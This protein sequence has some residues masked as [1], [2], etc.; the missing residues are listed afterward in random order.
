[1][2]VALRVNKLAD[3]RHDEGRQGPRRC[4]S[5]LDRGLEREAVHHGGEHAHGIAGRTRYAARGDF[6]AAD[7]VSAA[8]DHRDLGAELAGGDQFAGDPVDGRLIDAEGLRAGEVF[9]GEL[10]HHTT[11]DR[12]SHCETLSFPRGSLPAQTGRKDCS[13]GY[14]L[15]LA[16]A[17]SAAKSDS[18]F[19]IPSPR[20]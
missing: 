7:D 19:S 8:D 17:T 16:A 4:P 1:M 15:P 13:G 10:D 9:A 20:A 3:L 12:L 6:H 18:C 2:C 14:F 5:P 11:I